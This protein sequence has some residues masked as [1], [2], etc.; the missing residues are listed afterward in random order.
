MYHKLTPPLYKLPCCYS[1]FDRGTSTP[2]VGSSNLTLL[3]FAAV[4]D[5]PTLSI[6]S[7]Y[8][9][10]MRTRRIHTP[11]MVARENG[12]GGVEGVVALA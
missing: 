4:N 11:E 5:H 6:P 8:T 9:T 7:S 12:S 1:N 2:I 3:H 10:S